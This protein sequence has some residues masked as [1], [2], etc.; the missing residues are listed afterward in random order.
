[1]LLA[2]SYRSG[3]DTNEN[4][5]KNHCLKWNWQLLIPYKVKKHARCIPVVCMSLFGFAFFWKDSDS[6]TRSYIIQWLNAIWMHRLLFDVHDACKM[7]I[8]DESFIIS[9]ITW[10][11]VCTCAPMSD[12]STIVTSLLSQMRKECV[13]G[14]GCLF[15]DFTYGI[16]WLVCSEVHATVGHNPP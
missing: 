12:C 1:M 4:H 11:L 5:E 3:K 9:L 15:G 6:V 10:W 16:R 13:Y 2:V 8:V 14:R 7:A